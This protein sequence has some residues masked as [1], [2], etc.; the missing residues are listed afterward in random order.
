MKKSIG[1]DLGTTNSVAAIKK[2]RT[3][4]LKNAEGDFITPSCVTVRK[5]IIRKPEFI[6]GRHALEWQRQEPENTI[7]AVKRLIG[8]N[9]HD[10]E[11]QGLIEGHG[12]RYQL[13]AHSRG[14]ANSLA[15]L[16]A[17][18]EF[19]PE[20]I[21]AK[22]LIKIKEDAEKSL[23]DQVDSAVITV[24]AYFNDKQKH[25]TRT[26]AALAGLK[27]RRLLPEPT[28]AAVSFGVDLMAGEQKRSVL[29]FDF[30]GG[31]LDLSILT[32]NSGHI[33]ELGKGGDMWLGGE[34]IDRLLMEYV[35][36]ETAEAEEIDDIQALIE[37]QGDTRKNR[38]L[39]ELKTAVE[40]AKIALSERSTTC[41]E[42]LGIL[43]DQNGDALDIEVELS[44]KRFET[45]LVPMLQPMI[46]LI[47]RFIAEVHNKGEVIDHVLMVG[48]SSRIPC[49]IR[50]MQREF[51]LEKILIHQRPM[52]AVAEGAAILS[53]RLANTLECPDCGKEAG[54]RDPVCPHC[55]FDLESY[56]VNKGLVRIVHAA[57]HDYYIKL[58]NN[59]RFLMVKKNTPLPCSSTEIFQLVD[60]EQELVH[61]KF[62]NVVN[63]QE[64]S[65]GDLWLG[66]DTGTVEKEE[67]QAIVPSR[68]AITIDIDENNLVSVQANLVG[69]PE[70]KVAGTLSR[71]KADE[72][73]FLTLEQAINDADQQG[74]STYTI[75]DLLCRARAV[76][77][78]I[79][80]IV[81]PKTGEV[82]EEQYKHIQSK[83]S[84]A[85]QIAQ[86]EEAPL[87]RIY[88]A[89]TML[90]DYGPLIKPERQERIRKKIEHLRKVD[91]HGSYRETMQAVD[92]LS[93]AL[94]DKGLRI[95]HILTQ[96]ENACEIC[97]Q[98]DPEMAKKFMRT[99][100]ELLDAAEVGDPT[101]LEQAQEI[102]PE[103]DEILDSHAR[104]TQ[105]IYRDIRK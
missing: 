19:T 73:L 3:E 4:V 41:I 104:T 2:V 63:E 60:P 35:L 84:K 9:F 33:I 42:I 21:S 97:Y 39:A 37:Q 27:I 102:M 103:V 52:L 8:R 88:Y 80:N 17:G 92:A 53:H 56:T 20:E 69:M 77:H 11:V 57:A 46:R 47:R 54:Q 99:A 44:R 49:V 96:I 24:P 32:I 30:G 82:N 68:I 48:G 5:R 34:D 7:N 62:Y 105:K 91:E 79:R 94:E 50:L 29:V 25:A 85:V 65:I 43:L 15:I 61:M 58:E 36:Q 98:N 81:D 38:L 101:A 71:G 93:A 87:T 16:A 86:N 12:L 45:M 83:I 75:T 22:I 89:E 100:A 66:I 40:K 13:A 64:E 76:I 28:A 78:S 23:G 14:S 55:G 95:V 59:R 70:S 51:G 26:A 18:R 6:V 72:K 1:I 74:Y 90:E 31:T 10:H 67:Q